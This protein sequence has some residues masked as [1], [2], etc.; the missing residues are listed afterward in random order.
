MKDKAKAVF[1]D[2]E[3]VEESPGKWLATYRNDRRKPRP[4]GSG[5]T[6]KAAMRDLTDRAK[7]R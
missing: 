4:T 2:V 6:W 7:E 5:A 3:V 1:V